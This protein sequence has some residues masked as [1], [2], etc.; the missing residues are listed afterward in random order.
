MKKNKLFVTFSIAALTLAGCTYVD[1]NLLEPDAT[2]IDG[3]LTN[4]I[5][6]QSSVEVVENGEEKDLKKA[7]HYADEIY[8]NIDTSNVQGSLKLPSI[9][10]DF[11][12]TTKTITK[13]ETSDFGIMGSDGSLRS[14]V[15]RS[16]DHDITLTCTITYQTA[17][18]KKTFPIHIPALQEKQPFYEDTVIENFSSYVTGR[19]ISYYYDWN[20]TS[21]S[22]SEGNGIGEI[23]ESVPDNNM[24]SQKAIQFPSYRLS[25]DVQ[26]DRYITE[27]QSFA[28]ETYVMFR[29]KING[30]YFDF[31]DGSKR[32]VSAGITD[33]G[34]SYYQSG[35]YKTSPL[36]LDEGVWT[37][38][39]L[40]VDLTNSSY[41]YSYYDW[42]TNEL[43]TI[44][45]NVNMSNK[46][47]K[48]TK[49]RIK[50]PSG[51]KIGCSYL[52]DLNL[53]PSV[54]KNIGTNPNRTIGIGNI[55][56]F[57]TDELL[58]EKG[59][60]M[61]ELNLEVYNR[62]DR[63]KKLELD[64]DYTVAVS[65]TTNT[66][67]TGEFTRTYKITL[68]ETNEVK[69][70]TQN[71]YIDDKNGP[72]NIRTFVS[73]SISK[74][75]VTLSGTVSKLNSDVYYMIVPANSTAPT[76][77]Q[78]KAGSNY[79][80][81]TVSKSGKLD[82]C[83][84]AFTINISD[85]PETIEYDIYVVT[86]H[87]N[88]FSTVQVKK[89]VSTTINIE[90]CD[91]F[92]N[93]TINPDTKD[94]NFRLMNDIDFTNYEWFIN[95]S[96]TL[97]F[98]GQLDGQGY[99][100]K[101]LVIDNQDFNGTIIKKYGI[102]YELGSEDQTAYVKNINF[103]NC[104]ITSYEDTGLLAG[105]SYGSVVENITINGLTIKAVDNATGEGYLAALFGR[106]EKGETVINNVSIVDVNIKTYKYG[107]CVVA[108][109]QNTNLLTITNLIFIGTVDNEGAYA[110]IVG[111]NRSPLYVENIY[112][113]L[114][115]K[116]SKKQVGLIAGQTSCSGV[117]NG[118]F[119]A[120][121]IIGKL[122]VDEMMQPTYMN[123]AVGDY[124]DSA[125]PEN[126]YS[127][128][129]FYVFPQ[130]YSHLAEELIPIINSIDGAKD[131]N[132]PAE[133]TKAWWESNTCYSSLDSTYWYYDETLDRPNL[134]IAQ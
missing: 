73:S 99:T 81:V 75:K 98:V 55:V 100:I 92:Y 105:Y 43:K 54:N 33:N 58:L 134:K 109:S 127:I 34:F 66:S 87:A 68:K 107:G 37:K 48:I 41:T 65:G 53:A 71:I 126:D 78:I 129:N 101:N 14:S 42:Y 40:D 132:E 27:N 123:N 30:L 64:K 85:I 93:M 117:N 51:S 103:E 61:P 16:V 115:I 69:E 94:K 21:G 90:T 29:D 70:L 84:G 88:G 32:G 56:G 4:R 28:F 124:S 44:A 77:A 52:S 22:N 80:N 47:T 10:V 62:F 36:I 5:E 9:D 97:K 114:H 23:I 35:S 11:F 31:L 67:T 102:F 20:M 104:S 45:E 3:Y 122:S 118:T 108:N 17:V 106:V 111:R 49:L 60:E 50:V 89:S 13:W 125:T 110:G 128:E 57:S 79:G 130:D 38:I 19:E 7:L 12:G 8:F 24:V 74:N 82:N 39:R 6:N 119:T 131:L 59:D 2:I 25:T 26:Y 63:T 46:L 76:A 18:V 120:K 112:I 1:T 96:D 133:F 15:D 121:N 91:D 95:P 113:D 86:E 116:N 72:S 83:T